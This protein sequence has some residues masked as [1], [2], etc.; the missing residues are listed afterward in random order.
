MSTV[1]DAR[2]RRQLQTWPRH[3]SLLRRSRRCLRRKQAIK[4]AVESP[5]TNQAPERT[6]PEKQ[7]WKIDWPEMR[8]S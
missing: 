5:V 4:V 2:I 1:L 6:T 7:M 3:F 8:P